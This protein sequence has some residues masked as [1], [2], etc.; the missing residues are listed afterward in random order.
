MQEMEIKLGG[1]LGSSLKGLSY[2]KG[3]QEQWQLFNRKLHAQCYELSCVCLKSIR[4]GPTPRTSE[5]I[6]DRAFH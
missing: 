1:K 2:R 5:S 3:R 4:C 6:G